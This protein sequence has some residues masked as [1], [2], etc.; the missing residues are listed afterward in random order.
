MVTG[1]SDGFECLA[2]GAL[3]APA[4]IGADAAV[5]HAHV[6]VPFAL[7]GTHAA[8]FGAGLEQGAR[9]RRLERRLPGQDVRGRL[10]DV[11]TVEV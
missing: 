4:R 5:L 7:L 8:R 6:G 2:A 1:R 10:A 9:R 3:A 11:G